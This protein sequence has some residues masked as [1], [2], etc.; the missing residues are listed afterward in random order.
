M[1]VYARHRIGPPPSAPPRESSGHLALRAYVTFV[2]FSALATTFWF[3]LIGAVGLVVLVAVSTAVSVILWVI[4]R[5]PVNARRLPWYA[6]LYVVWAAASALWTHW[7]DA[8]ALTWALLVCTTVQGLFVASVLTWRELTAA[9]AAALKWVLGLSLLFELWVALIVHA[10]VLPNFLAWDGAYVT[11]LAWSRGNLFDL[12]RRIQGI[13]GNAHLMA[14]AALLALVV[15]GLLLAGRGQRRGWLIAWTVLAAVLFWRSESATVWLAAGAVVLVLA[16]ALLMRTTSRP[17]ERTKYYVA[18]AVLGGGLV[19]A[20]WFLRDTILGV[21]GKSGDLTGRLGIWEAVA[22]R[23]AEHPVLG[24]GFT[25]PWLPWEPDFRDWIIVNDLPVFHAH[26]VWLDVLFQ[27]GAIGAALLALT[28]AAV[29]WRSWFFAI[30]RP[31][32]DLVADR[33]YQTVTLLPLLVVTILLVQ[34]LAESRPLMEWGWMFVV[35]LAMKIKQAPLV[36]E[37]PMEQRLAM[38]RGE[39]IG[40]RDRRMRG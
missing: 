23:I 37:G 11:E 33:P 29:I 15:F 18:Y 6:M 25:T 30:D 39:F 21:F 36:G 19:V 9:I 24:W 22:A 40:V 13:V 5:P 2:L 38:E 14:I 28:Y 26:N 34:G 27:V 32:F 12:D 8:T 20:A 17:G 1:A 3:N 4:L 31:R 7:L 35:M 16:T 10:P